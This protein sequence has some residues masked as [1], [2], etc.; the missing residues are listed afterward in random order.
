MAKRYRPVNRDQPFLFPPSMRDWLP[1]GHPVWLVI[2][3]VEDHLDTSAFPA[4]RKTGGAGG[5]PWLDGL[6]RNLRAFLLSPF[7]RQR[8]L[9]F[10]SRPRLSDLAALRDLVESGAIT[11]ALDRAYPLTEAAAA[12]R[13]LADGHARG[14]VVISV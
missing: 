11:P 1:E 4:A 7:V 10:I 3:A 14:K 8:L 12:V 2:T 13:R 5:G 6:D 9:A